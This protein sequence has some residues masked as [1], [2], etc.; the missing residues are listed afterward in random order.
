MN[1]LFFLY[2]FISIYFLQFTFFCYNCLVC[3]LVVDFLKVMVSMFGMIVDL[4]LSSVVGGFY[5]VVMLFVC[6]SGHFSWNLAFGRMF[7]F[8]SLW[9]FL[10]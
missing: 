10:G 6:Y 2:V 9:A 1:C 4:P 5:F 7:E 3:P 8:V